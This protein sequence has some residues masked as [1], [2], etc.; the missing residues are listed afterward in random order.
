[1]KNKVGIIL[2]IAIA[3]VTASCSTQKLT[4]AQPQIYWVNSLKVSCT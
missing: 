2:V 4:T 1:M 3:I